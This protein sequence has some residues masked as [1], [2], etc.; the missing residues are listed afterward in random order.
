[1]PAPPLE[2]SL[3]RALDT[4]SDYLAAKSRVEAAR[5]V[6][7]ARRSARCCPRCASTPTTARS[8]RRSRRRTARTRSP[9]PC[10]SRSSTAAARRRGASRRIGRCASARRSS[11][12]CAGASSTRSARRCSICA[13][14]TSSC[15]RR[16]PTSSS[17]A[18]QLQQ[19]RDRFAAGVAGNLEVTQAQEAVATASETYIAALYA[20]NLAKASLARAL[21][22]AESAVTTLSRRTAVMAAEERIGR[23]RVAWRRGVLVGR[24]ASSGVRSRGRRVDRRR[25]GGRTDHAD[26]GARRRHGDQGQRRQQPAGRAPAPCS[27][28]SIRATTR[29]PS[30]ARAPSWPTPTATA[31][32]GADRRADRARRDAAPASRTAS[33]GVRAGGG[34]GHRR[35]AARCRS[36]RPT[37][38]RRRRASA[39]RRR[40]R[41]RRRTT[42]SGC[43]RWSQKDEIPQQQ[44]DAAVAPGRC[45]ARR[46]RRGEVRRHRR[47]R[48][49]IAV[50]QQR[51][52]QARGAAAQARGR[53]RNRRGPR[54]QQLQVTQARA[55]S[56]RGAR[57]AGAGG[58]RAGGAEPRST[59]PS[60]RPAAG[61]VS[62]KTRRSRTGHS[63]RAAADGARRSRATSGS[64]RTSRRRSSSGCSPA[65]RRRSTSTRSA[66]ARSTAHVDS[67]AAATGAKFSLL[68]P[69]NATG[70]FV[71]VV[72]RIPV[73]ICARA[74][75]GSRSPAAPGHVSVTPTVY[76][77]VGH[78]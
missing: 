18:E 48:A 68:P 50:A 43:D 33:G 74:G 58:A 64:P 15:R 66:A 17:R 42:S 54:P 69:E 12:T 28:R 16:A 77:E 7:S 70:N 61:I 73:K 56:A 63:A 34:G 3:A 23:R 26:R 78:G 76:V 32:G 75:R 37:S 14:P 24:R 20:H 49:A 8:D 55:A 72:Q 19:A 71:K 47:R 10:A 40:P 13:P 27:C 6:A 31:R 30:T 52:A 25:A 67:I 53:P 57:A 35:R 65:R 22:I 21:G 51:V 46:G 2:T 29:S 44:F 4:R 1:M 45:G 11:P 39:K 36:R 5:G 60:R 38:S 41:R 62:R 9:R 59:R